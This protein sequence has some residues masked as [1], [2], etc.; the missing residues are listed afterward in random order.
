M[1][2]GHLTAGRSDEAEGRNA[3]EAEGLNEELGEL[4]AGVTLLVFG[5]VLLGP[6]LSHL[7]W[8][9]VVYAV[10]SLTAVRMLPV[11]AAM[12]GSH[13]RRATVAFLGWFGPRGLASIVFAVI[14]VQEAHLPGT[15]SILLA[16]YATVGLSVFAH[17]LSAAPLASAYVRWYDSHP[18]DR[19]PKMESVPVTR[20]R[21]R[22]GLT[23]G[24]GRSRAIPGL[25]STSGAAAAAPPREAHPP[26]AVED[27]PRVGN[28]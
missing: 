1:V 2:F 9:V 11:A 10:A 17:G 26:T 23:A 28:H 7:T 5:A 22:G 16:A 21:S 13:A 8:Q 12:V 20:H 18:R 14:V 27:P 3:E 24:R 6:R 25:A 4:L 19:R 15:G